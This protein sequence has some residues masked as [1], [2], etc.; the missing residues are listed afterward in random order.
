MAPEL[1]MT[2]LPDRLRDVRS[3]IVAAAQR[4]GRAPETVRLIA[5]SKRKPASAIRAAYELG[6]R[7]FG[8][9]YVQELSSKRE[10]LEDLHDIRWHLIGH[11]QSKK[12]RQVAPIVHAVHTMDSAK[13]VHELS[14]RAHAVGRQIEAFVEVNLAEEP[15]KAGATPGQL[16]ALVEVLTEAPSLRLV[17]L[18]AIPPAAETGDALRSRFRQLRDL[19][20]EQSP[21]L[22]RLS[23]G[24]SADFE[25]AIEEG[26]TEVRVGTGIFGARTNPEAAAG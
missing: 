8:E 13:L 24:M 2:E 25:V 17:G 5:V 18:M 3:R 16:P 1:D 11:L 4:A 26:A 19:A 23:M 12:A 9:N 14:R 15:Q 21:P 22:S 6:V 10:Q 7:D 20:A